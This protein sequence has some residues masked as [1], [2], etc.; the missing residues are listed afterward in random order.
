MLTGIGADGTKYTE[1]VTFASELALGEESPT[2]ELP[3]DAEPAG[4]PLTFRLR[5]FLLLMSLDW[6][7][8]GD[9]GPFA[10]SVGSTRR[11]CYKCMW[12]ASCPCAFMSL[13]NP[14]RS[15]VQHT[16]NCRGSQPR[17]HDGVMAVV[18]ELR[19]LETSGATKTAMKNMRTENGIF[20]AHFASEHLLR[21]VVKDPTVD[22]MHVF[23]AGK[24][25]Y[26]FSWVTDHF[27]PDQF[28][29][30][31]LNKA[32]N[33]FPF[34]RSGVR[35]PDLE[36]SKGSHRQSCS[37]HLNAAQMMTFAIARFDRPLPPPPPPPRTA[38][39]AV[40]PSPPLLLP[41]RTPTLRAQTNRHLISA[42][43]IS[44]N[45]DD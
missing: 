16:A 9:F 2:I 7:A 40:T 37:I 35:V 42:H 12:T 24:T 4:A 45:W 14:R 32:K 38:P 20:S 44:R 28:G 41:H 6:L 31:D 33:R 22:T 17:T 11:P 36:Y 27:I 8:H 25:R 29:W 30:P 15:T 34:K 23:F 43:Y 1:G 13:D 19:R 21:D 18:A 39:R 5:L 26:L 3:N 10:A